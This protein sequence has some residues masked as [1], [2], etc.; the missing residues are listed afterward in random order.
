MVTGVVKSCPELLIEQFRA[1]NIQSHI[2]S[3]PI[4]EKDFEK[5]WLPL[6]EKIEP[7]MLS[8]QSTVSVEAT[9]VESSEIL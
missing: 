1:R 9:F 3:G 8:Q 4:N 5:E 7:V 2:S 6:V